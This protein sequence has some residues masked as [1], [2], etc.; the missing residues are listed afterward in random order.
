MNKQDWEPLTLAKS[1][2]S[3]PCLF[4]SCL[5]RCLEH[6][7]RSL[8]EQI[9][10]QNPRLQQCVHH[11]TTYSFI[12]STSLMVKL[13]EQVSDTGT[14]LEFRVWDVYLVSTST[15]GWVRKRD[16]TETQVQLWCSL[17]SWPTQQWALEHVLSFK[18][19][20]VGPKWQQ[21]KPM[22]WCH[23]WQGVTSRT[24]LSASVDPKG[25]NICLSVE[26]GW[27]NPPWRKIW[28]ALGDLALECDFLALISGPATPW[29]SDPVC[30]SIFLSILWC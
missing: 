27:E 28:A 11:I 21:F 29:L 8:F 23:P 7:G 3:A 26:A 4:C 1:L 15:E 17:Q 22:S 10:I 30:G 12:H 9:V 14:E 5:R 18:V 25:V 2:P 6:R 19:S 13:V 16:G 20:C 24:W